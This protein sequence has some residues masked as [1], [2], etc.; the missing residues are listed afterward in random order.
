MSIPVTATTDAPR[1]PRTGRRRKGQ[2]DDVMVPEAEFSSYY[3]RNIVKPAPWKNE[4]PA[5][6][7]LGGLAAGSALVAVGGE[8]TQRRELQRN[9]R[10]IAL[11]A[12]TGSTGAL[13]MDLGKPSRFYN[14]MRTV[15]LTSPM[16]VGSW[17]LA[18]FGVFTGTAAVSEVMRFVVPK[19][20][21]GQQFWPI[22]D[23]LASI[24][25]GAFSAPLA[26][27]TAVLLADTATPTWHGSYKQLPF[28]FVG[29]ALAAAGGAAMTCTSVEECGPARRLAVGGTVLEL[30]MF[31]VMER[32][33]GMLAEPLHEGKAG[34]YL[35][36]AK[37]SGVLGAALTLTVGC[38]RLGAAAAGIALNAASALT[39]F[40]VFEAGMASARD[41]K[42]TVVPQRERLERRLEEKRLTGRVSGPTR[43]EDLRVAHHTATAV[44]P[45]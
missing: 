10:L 21:P 35:K 27:Y 23:R 20:V 18:G 13:I 22:G 25:A 16:S 14:M 39:R 41:P 17:I 9:S 4:I 38:T 29:S 28:V 19:S 7:Y 5:Y 8:F 12:L 40:G 30:A 24:G 44:N 32:E 3:G 34:R 45:F 11:A 33:L 37:I 1:T 6:L 2:R 31:S 26:A 43:D 36:G 42:Y 15:K